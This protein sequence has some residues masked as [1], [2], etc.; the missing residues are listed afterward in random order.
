MAGFVAAYA[1]GRLAIGLVHA[2][3]AS[4]IG[5]GLAGTITAVIG[6]LM[7]LYNE[8][9]LLVFASLGPISPA[10]SG[11]GRP[12]VVLIALAFSLLTAV[13]GLVGGLLGGGLRSLLPW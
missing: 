11:L 10:L 5:G 12:S 3:F 7:G 8:P 6:T 1:A 9:P 4:A 2:M 13:D